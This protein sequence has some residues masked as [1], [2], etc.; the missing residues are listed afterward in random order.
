MPVFAERLAWV[1]F[2]QAMP[3]TAFT[4]RPVYPP[5]TY[6]DISNSEPIS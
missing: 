4:D 6:W 2:T 5:T 1:A 3:L